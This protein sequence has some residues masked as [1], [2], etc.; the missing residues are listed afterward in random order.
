MK[1][2]LNGNYK[3]GVSILFSEEDKKTGIFEI[4]GY[5]KQILEPGDEITIARA[6]RKYYTVIGEVERRDAKGKWNNDDY[7]NLY[8]KCTAT[9]N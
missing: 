1:V 6:P 3:E 7:K 5:S 2:L 8:F 9:K 4:L